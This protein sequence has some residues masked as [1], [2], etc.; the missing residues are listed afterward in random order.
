MTGCTPITPTHPLPV[1]QSAEMVD[2]AEKSDALRQALARV[3]RRRHGQKL[4]TGNKTALGLALGSEE[5]V[6]PTRASR[7][8]SGQQF[9]DEYWDAVAEWA[10][11]TPAGLLRELAAELERTD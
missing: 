8:L 11:L 4:T 1:A 3:L 9:P 5:R 7:L 6:A 2:K 10:G